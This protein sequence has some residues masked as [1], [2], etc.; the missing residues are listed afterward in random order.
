MNWTRVIL[1]LCVFLLCACLVFAV[2]ALTALRNAV[3]EIAR[4]REDATETASPSGETE[5]AASETETET[6]EP[7]QQVGVLYDRF[8]VREVGGRVAVYAASGELIRLTD[9]TVATLPK[10]DRDALRDGICF[11]SWREVL[12][13]L[14]DLGA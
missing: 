13:L 3:S 11:Q 8:C 1:I 12:S 6:A 2:T 14:E 10:A 7:S 9:V 4:V 5:V